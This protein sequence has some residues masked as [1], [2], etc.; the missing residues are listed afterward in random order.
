MLLTKIT[1][2]IKQMFCR[3]KYYNEK[4]GLY[5]IVGIKYRIDYLKADALI[6]T[7]DGIWYK[8]PYIWLIKNSMDENGHPVQINNKW[9]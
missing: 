2:Y 3:P 1:N 6:V 5:N 9:I 4:Y 8:V 7:D